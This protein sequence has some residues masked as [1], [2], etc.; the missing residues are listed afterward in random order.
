[1]KLYIFLI[2]SFFASHSFAIET[3]RVEIFT[4]TGS[5]NQAISEAV[6]QV[7]RDFVKS[8]IGEDKYL[9][10]ENQFEDKIIKNKNRYIIFTKTST[11]QETEDGKFSTKVSLGLSEENL[12][13][14][15]LENNLFYNTN[16]SCILPVFAFEFENKH[17]HSWW[18][19]DQKAPSFL[20]EV[21][22]KFYQSFSYQLIKLG[23]YTIN[24][25]HSQFLE[26]FPQNLL[27]TKSR[28]SDFKKFSEFVECDLVIV[29]R[30]SIEDDKKT[31]IYQGDSYLKFINIKTK[32]KLFDFTKKFTLSKADLL[33]RFDENLSSFFRSFNYQLGFY[34]QSGSLD[35]SL[36]FLS[37]QGSI[38]YY[39]KERIKQ[40]L[41]ANIKSIKN[42]K[43]NR[44]TSRQ[45]IY[46]LESSA[47]IK[48]IVKDIEKNRI[49]K[50][51][52]LK[53]TNYSKN[54]LDIY[55][56]KN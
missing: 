31:E 39:D 6:Y 44:I 11:P 40:A 53:V 35:L 46:N 22:K 13:A 43:E 29:G 3:I 26:S 50:N 55:V 2:L 18:L 21:A 24:P 23:F 42:L 4:D 37:L 9:Q 49:L 12:K 7:S 1:M 27:P 15:L 5:K 47:K 33:A 56:I 19:P 52:K 10:N 25:Y 41:V 16:S 20:L 38:N 48:D 30:I 45:V 34:K 54:R 32:Q 28:L 36:L 8:I 14:L 17:K 51:F